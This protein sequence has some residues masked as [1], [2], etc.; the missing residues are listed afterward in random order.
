MLSRWEGNCK[1]DVFMVYTPMGCKSSE[2][3]E[4][5]CWQFHSSHLTLH[6]FGEGLFIRNKCQYD[7]RGPCDQSRAWQHSGWEL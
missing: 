2:S 3:I 7:C 1:S 4:A 6:S 5:Q